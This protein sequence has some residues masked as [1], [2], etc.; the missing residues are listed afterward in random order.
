MHTCTHR[1]AQAHTSTHTEILF[2][3]HNCLFIQGTPVLPSQG[4][5]PP[6]PVHPSVR[7][8]PPQLTP[9]E[10][11]YR[12]P[13]PPPPGAP[14]YHGPPRPHGW[15]NPV[16]MRPPSDNPPPQLSSNNP[17]DRTQVCYCVSCLYNSFAWESC[18][19]T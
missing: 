2:I 16:M 11:F 15:G 5:P 4:G 17:L 12:Q 19:R 18:S 13:I 8:P 6:P 10:P 1:H 14:V 9:G 7:M 3:I